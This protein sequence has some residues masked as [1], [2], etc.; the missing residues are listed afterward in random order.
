MT[1]LSIPMVDLKQQYQQLKSEIDPL[2]EKVFS[3]TQFILGPEVKRF[4]Q[5][6]AEYLQVKHAISVASGTDALHLALD[7]CGIQPGDEVITTSFSF[8]ATA[9]AI[10]YLQ[11]KPVFV[12]IDPVTMNMDLNKLE[13]AI[14]DKTKAILPVHLFG[15]AMAMPTLLKLAKRHNLKVIEDCAQSFGA[16]FEGRFAG[17]F[18]ETGCF[19]FFPSKNLGAYGDGGLVSTNDDAIAARLFQLRNH[20]SEKRYYHDV[21]GF[22]SRLDEIQA[23]ILNI[24]MQYIQQYNEQRRRVAASYHEKL[25]E[26]PLQCPHEA[27]ANTHVYHQ[28]TILT[29][30]RDQIQE[31]LQHARIASAIYYPVPIHQ[32]KVFT[33]HA[34]AIS[35]PVTEKVA[36]ECLSLPIFPEMTEAQI[37]AVCDVVRHQLS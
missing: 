3:S 9:E 36:A 35:L 28:Y 7:G 19:S 13:A 34:P 22:N 23:A 24:K 20:G 10:C 8:I 26:L 37:E 33:Q 4:E 21:I 25:A 5:S 27:V 31:A 29:S 30:A 2:L 12:D 32:Q 11:A 1:T 14:T 16:A 17:A 15:Q 18:G 6:V